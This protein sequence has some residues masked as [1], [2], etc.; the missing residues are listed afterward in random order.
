MTQTDRLLTRLD[1]LVDRLEQLLPS[2]TATPDWSA[3]AFRWRT[4]AGGGWLQ[5]VHTPHRLELADLLGLERQKEEIDRNTAQFI[6]GRGANNVLLWGSRGTG[7]SS[8]V[9][10][11]FNRYRDQGLRL[12][13]VDKDDLIQL[14]DI[15]DLI[16]DRPERFILFC[17]DLSFEANESSYKALKAALDGSIA[18]TP[19]NVLIYA[20]SN[21]RHLLPEFHS[22]NREARIQDGELHHGESVEEKISLS[23]RFGLW[24]SFHPFNQTQYLGVVRHWLERLGAEPETPE[25]W[26][27][28]ERSALQWALR[29]G[30]RSG[31]TA[32]Q[33]AKDWAGRVN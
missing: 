22:E 11:V 33:F 30:S 4:K 17:D 32:W 3:H 26:E 25:H 19:D 8:L 6:A 24:V 5:A 31:R 12:I 29:R 2:G 1:A 20:T 23:D 28:I 21:R 7:K 10:A 15:L 18:A 9:K 16:H 13:E 14:P 27:A